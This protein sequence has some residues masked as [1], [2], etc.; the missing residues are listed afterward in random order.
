MPKLATA[1]AVEQIVELGG[2]IGE[3]KARLNL[4]PFEL[5]DASWR[6]G[7]PCRQ[8]HRRAEAGASLVARTRRVVVARTK[9]LVR[10][11]SL[12]A[13]FWEAVDKRTTSGQSAFEPT[14]GEPVAA[15][16]PCTQNGSAVD[17]R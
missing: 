17:D 4:E 10:G 6:R 9:G 1:P 14:F 2:K 13:A 3:L 11:T 15:L 16:W 7:D 8:T 12:H 5:H